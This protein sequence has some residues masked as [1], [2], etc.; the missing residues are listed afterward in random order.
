MLMF[1]LTHEVYI[2]ASISNLIEFSF[3]FA[4]ADLVNPQYP[5]HR[6]LVLTPYKAEAIQV[7]MWLPK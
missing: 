6:S 5:V 4:I 3:S 2:S 1:S 7:N